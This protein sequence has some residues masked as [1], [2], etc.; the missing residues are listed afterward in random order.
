MTLDLAGH[1][2]SGIDRNNWTMAAFG[3]DVVAVV[4]YLSLEQ[5]VLIGHSL[6]APVVLETAQRVQGVV[7]VVG[8]DQLMDVNHK[9][10]P[11]QLTR[12]AA[13]RSSPTEL[14]LDTARKFASSVI[15]NTSDPALA[16]RIVSDMSSMPPN[17]IIGVFSNEI[18]GYDLGQVLEKVTTPVWCISSDKHPFNLEAARQHCPSFEVL[19]MSGVG[20]FVMMEDPETFNGLLQKIVNTLMH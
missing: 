10:D 18:L 9:A 1:G 17:A 7:G 16:E 4:N 19:F 15:V 8:V 11:N 20:H 13:L 3:E 5:V 6:G 14:V 2:E 12:L